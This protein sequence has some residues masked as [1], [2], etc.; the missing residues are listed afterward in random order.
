LDK[1]PKPLKTKTGL[2]LLLLWWSTW[3]LRVGALEVLLLV[4]VVVLEA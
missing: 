4:V 1:R 3:S 2:A